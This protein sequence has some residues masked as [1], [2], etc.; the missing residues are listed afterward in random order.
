MFDNLLYQNASALLLNDIE[1]GNLPGS[2]L[3]SGPQASGKLTCALE[4]ARVLS[5]TGDG[6]N[7]KGH[8]LCECAQCKK[9]KELANAN[10][11]LAGPR[12]CFLEIQAAK[13]AFLNAAYNNSRSLT[14]CRYLFIRSV[15]KLTNRFS[16][17]L[18]EDD[19]KVPKIAQVMQAIDDDMEKL[20]PDRE[21]LEN[22]KLDKTVSGISEQCEKLE[23]SFMYESIPIN[24]IRNAASWARLKSSEGKKV[25]I[26]ENAERMLESARNALLKILEEPPEDIV[27]ILTTSC[28][29]AVMPTILSRVRTYSF[30]E[31]TQKQQDEVIDRVF[32]S[33]NDKKLSVAEYLETFLPVNPEQVKKTAGAYFLSLMEGNIVLPQGIVSACNGFSPLVLFKIFLTGI[34]ESARTPLQEV[35]TAENAFFC[36]KIVEITRKCYNNVTVYNQ[37]PVSAI[38]VLSRDLLSIRRL[39]R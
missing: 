11:L 32:H 33:P 3:L 31:R 9:S 18:L 5:C 24:Q 38:E 27:F 13:K 23:S 35:Q 28:R 17:V 14:A 22:D 2:I 10:V 37:S 25:F 20:S 29:Q 39:W 6:K 1:N 16:Q 19:D 26:I 12:D 7:Q 8:W 21:L 34:M 36:E 30:A 4:L 15:R